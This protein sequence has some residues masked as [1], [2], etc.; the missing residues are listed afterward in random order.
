MNILY[1]PGNSVLNKEEAY[2]IKAELSKLGHNV[3]V[4]EWRHWVDQS[5]HWGLNEEISRI[6]NLKLED[7]DIVI[8]KSIGS[9]VASKLVSDILVFP[10]KVVL[11]GLP[12]NSELISI[13][14]YE[15]CLA[16]MEDNVTLIQNDQDP[17]G[18]MDKVTQ[19]SKNNPKAKLVV[20][21][22]NNHIYNYPLD[23][24]QAIE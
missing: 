18:P 1:L 15:A 3:V 20:K 8:G 10:K 5:M 6:K 14:V 23:I 9:F 22:A 2:N 24:I 19:L 12:L 17:F 13:D 4:H 21:I 16:R 11:L 7:I